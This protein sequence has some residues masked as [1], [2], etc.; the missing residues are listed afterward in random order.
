[1]YLGDDDVAAFLNGF[2][3]LWHPAA[4]VGAAG[5]PRLASPYDHEQPHA[6]ALYALPETPPL[7]LPDDW[8]HRA[9]DAGASFFKATPNRETTLANLKE[10]LR[11]KADCS[12]TA[13]LDLG[14]GQTGPFF[15]VG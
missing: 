10:A 5:L 1:L 12:M 6:A 13:L 9:R 3:A 4:L 14:P 8:E 11:E 7:M 15:G 2:A